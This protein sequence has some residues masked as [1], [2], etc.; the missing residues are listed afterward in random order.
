MLIPPMRG[1]VGSRRRCILI[2]LILLAAAPLAAQVQWGQLVE[3]TY[4]CEI[5]RVDC[6]WRSVVEGEANEEWLEGS[7]LY[8]YQETVW[9]EIREVS[10]PA[11]ASSPS[12]RPIRAMT[13]PA[14][15]PARMCGGLKS[16]SESLDVCAS[17]GCR[18][19]HCNTV[20]TGIY[21]GIWL[22]KCLKMK[23]N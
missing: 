16:I 9:S 1:R 7:F 20:Q 17:G 8:S 13:A 14:A 3:R 23:E 18:Q 5:A 10:P 11:G 19:A 21:K 4:P 22:C 2:G 12:R 15:P 6:P